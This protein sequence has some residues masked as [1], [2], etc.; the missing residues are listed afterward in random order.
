MS[1]QTALQFIQRVRRDETLRQKIAALGDE[2]SGDGVS[3]EHLARVAA[4]AGFDFTAEELRAA[5]KFDWAMRWARYQPKDNEHS[6][7]DNP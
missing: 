6:L 5:H 3:A 2:A 1:V 4:A 7:T